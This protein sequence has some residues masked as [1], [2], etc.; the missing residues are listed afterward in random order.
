MT[1]ILLQCALGYTMWAI[2]EVLQKL[3]PPNK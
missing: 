1:M 3:Y 2:I